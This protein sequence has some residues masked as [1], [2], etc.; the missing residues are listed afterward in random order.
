MEYATKELE[1]I[2]DTLDKL[3][4]IVVTTLSK[5]EQKKVAKILK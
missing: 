3:L 5:E 1:R 4:K 2:A